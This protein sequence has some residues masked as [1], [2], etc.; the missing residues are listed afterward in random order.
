M[1]ASVSGVTNLF[2][3]SARV[4]EF[5]GVGIQTGHSGK[6]GI[7]EIA[8]FCPTIYGALVVER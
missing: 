8:E 1:A 2:G 6:Q 3:D 4:G 7:V 5:C